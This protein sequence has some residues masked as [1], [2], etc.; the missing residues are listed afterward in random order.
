MKNKKIIV[1]CM[2]VLLLVSCIGL[3]VGNGVYIVGGVVG[4][5]VFG[6]VVG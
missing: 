4:G 1:S 3:E 5:V 2:L 6:V